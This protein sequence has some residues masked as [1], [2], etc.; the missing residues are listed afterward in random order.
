M[1]ALLNRVLLN[2]ELF[3][4][5]RLGKRLPDP[6]GALEKD[7]PTLLKLECAETIGYLR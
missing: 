4:V 1:L 5:E 2:T 6:G 3:C 7:E